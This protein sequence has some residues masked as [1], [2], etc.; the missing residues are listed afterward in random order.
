MSHNILKYNANSFDVNSNRTETATSLTYGFI[1][2][3]DAPTPTVS[4]PRN[5]VTGQS[6][7]I[8]KSRVDN[9]FSTTD[10]EFNDW[11]T[12]TNFINSVTL[13]T[14]GVYAVHGFARFR[15]NLADSLVG[16]QGFGLH[17][18][19]NYVSNQFYHQYNEQDYISD[20]NLYTIVQVTGGVAVTMYIRIITIDDSYIN[21]TAPRRWN[22]LHVEKLQ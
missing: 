10:V 19:T 5:F 16:Y 8:Y 15:Y 17:D 14:N 4:Y 2:D 9:N 7:L 12:N 21:K 6:V 18:G 20:P 1:Q 22:Y 13:K 11:P 3:E